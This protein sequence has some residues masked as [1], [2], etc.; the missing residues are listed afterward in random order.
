M[1]NQMSLYDFWVWDEP[2]LTPEEIKLA[3]KQINEKYFEIE[4][5]SDGAQNSDGSFKKNIKPKRI[6]LGDHTTAI[7]NL[8]QKVIKTCHCEFGYVT[9]PPNIY[10]V[11]LQNVYSSKIK[12]HYGAHTDSSRS[13]IFDTKM[14]MLINLSEGTY[15]GGELI[16]NK[17][18]AETFRTPGSVVLFKSHLWHEVTPVTDGD[19]IS[20]A[21]F[22]NG[23]KFN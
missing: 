19:R 11:T 23:P 16:I 5:P 7:K 21:Y 6:Y 3:N 17:Q 8:V 14:T 10:D 15:T 13:T 22:I 4:D 2:Q 9:F 20:L 1:E 18:P 12:G